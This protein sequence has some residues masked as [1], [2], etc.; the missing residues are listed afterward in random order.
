M[1]AAD[2]ENKLEGLH[3]LARPLSDALKG[4]VYPLVRRELVL[5]ARENDAPATLLTLISGMRRAGPYLSL[6]EVQEALDESES[7]R[8]AAETGGVVPPAEG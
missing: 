5:V 6:A 7:A 4:A 8:V 2:L 1:S 3:P